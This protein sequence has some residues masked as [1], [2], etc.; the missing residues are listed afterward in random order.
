MVKGLH[1]RISNCIFNINQ[2]AVGE[3]VRIIL[4]GEISTVDLER[5]MIYEGRIGMNE[6][7]L[8]WADKFGAYKTDDLVS[9]RINPEMVKIKDS[10]VHFKFFDST[11]ALY[12]PGS[13]MYQEKIVLLQ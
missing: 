5:I 3:C 10:K 8:T 12:P 4:R 7:F 6:A 9:F 1:Q 11:Y 13:R 2:L